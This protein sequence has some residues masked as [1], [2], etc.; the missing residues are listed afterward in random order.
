MSDFAQVTAALP[1]LAKRLAQYG[2]VG[3]GELTI[4]HKFDNG[5]SN[6]TYLMQSDGPPFVVRKQP[7][8]H[9]MPRAHDVLREQ[10]MMTALAAAGYKAPRPIHACKDLDVLG[11][12]FFVMA[13]VPGAVFSGAD[14]PGC[15]QAE[16]AGVYR[17]MAEAMADLLLLSPDILS[18]AGFRPRPDFVGR[19]I[20]LWQGQYLASLPDDVPL[21]EAVGRWLQGAK[22]ERE[23]SGI[24]HGDF[25]LENLIFQG[26]TVAAVLDW[27]LAAIGEPLCDLGYCCLWYHLPPNVLGGLLGCDLQSLGIPSEATFLEIYAAR[28]GLAAVPD[29][30][31]FV[32]LALFR[33]AAILQGVYRR[34]MD[35]NAASTEALDR[36]RI[37]DVLLDQA[38]GLAGLRPVNPAS[39][40]RSSR[41][42]DPGPSQCVRNHA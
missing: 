3:A 39:S 29:H 38:A 1:R 36:G 11:T 37:A 23:C 18:A 8:G 14:L 35:G 40:F 32:T 27:E 42:G 25:R 34:S 12:E 13:Y 30:R 5:Q 15:S 2:V 33:L 10:T 24:V 16:R 17:A 9:L 20:A 4:V 28:R 19:Q 21:V 6:P 7:Y 31:F 41:G 26:T 22:P